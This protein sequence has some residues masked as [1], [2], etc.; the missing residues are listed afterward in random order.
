MAVYCSLNLDFI[1]EMLL[2]AV[3]ER[4]VWETGAV[5]QVIYTQ[6]ILL[7]NLI[8]LKPELNWTETTALW[9]KYN[10]W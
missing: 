7:G 2:Y 10:M 6:V 4:N 8:I 9:L 1:Q 5:L 3:C